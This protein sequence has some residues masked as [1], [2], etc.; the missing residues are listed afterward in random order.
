MARDPETLTLCAMPR[1]PMWTDE[2]T[3][4]T[5]DDAALRTSIEWR[6]RSIDVDEAAIA[7]LQRAVAF[8]ECAIR[9][10]TRELGLR[11]IERR[12]DRWMGEKLDMCV[13][14]LLAYMETMRL[15]PAT[16]VFRYKHSA[17][18]ERTYDGVPRPLTIRRDGQ[19]V[20]H[21]LNLCTSDVRTWHVLFL[22]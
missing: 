14:L 17:R 1:N 18:I 8:H 3:L 9:L 10:M 19:V 4:V 15:M 11:S 20:G 7:N 13:E 16:A 12:R 2:D 6:H 22:N 21:D 5:A